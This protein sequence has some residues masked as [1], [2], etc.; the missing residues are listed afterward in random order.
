VRNNEILRLTPRTNDAVNSA[1]MCDH[2]RLNTFKHVNADDR[3]KAPMIRKDGRLMEVGWDEAVARVASELH[4]FKKSEIAALGSAYETNEDNYVFQKFVRDVLGTKYSDVAAH[5]RPGDEDALLIRSDKT[6]NSAGARAMGAV[7]HPETIALPEILAGIKEGKIKALYSLDGNLADVPEIA[8]V[9]A[10]LEFLVVHSS[11]E[12]AT[13]RTA[14]VVFAASTYAEKNG[15]MT[16]CDGHVQRIRP[17]VATLEQDRA[18]DGFAMSRWDKFAAHNDR[19]GKGPR[20]DARPSWKIIAA[21]SALMG[22]RM[23]YA[24][25]EDVFQEITQKIDRYKG[26][27]YLKIGTKGVRYDRH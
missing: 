2:G 17:A 26:L 5:V 12:N 14:D 25:A 1:W 23:K 10:K 8:D 6:P 15:T 20:R 16:N 7:G 4:S 27:S 18:M 22:T 9:L 21:V 24:Q 19:W 13:T 11:N 3:V